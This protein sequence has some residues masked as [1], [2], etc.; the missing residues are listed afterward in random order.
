MLPRVPSYAR[1]GP[2]SLPA[3]VSW[4]CS[5]VGEELSESSALTGCYTLW[6]GRKICGV[7]ECRSCIPRASKRLYSGRWVLCMSKRSR[8]IGQVISI[9]CSSSTR[10]DA[11]RV[12]CMRC[13][14]LERSLDT[15]SAQVGKVRIAQESNLQP[16]QSAAS[17]CILFKC[18]VETKASGVLY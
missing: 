16:H 4:C 13:C 9:A 7:T 14:I 15:A 6:V 8:A 12:S 18:G 11:S 17:V 1:A 2:I 10:R 3:G 5:R